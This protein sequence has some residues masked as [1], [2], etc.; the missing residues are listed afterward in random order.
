MQAQISAHAQQVSHHLQVPAYCM[1]A[2][3]TGLGSL[4]LLSAVHAGATMGTMGVTMSAAA[5]Q[6]KVVTVDDKT[7]INWQ[8]QTNIRICNE[9][10]DVIAL[11][12]RYPS[13]SCIGSKSIVDV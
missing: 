3:F 11:M 8:V 13:A 5:A 7:V 10:L 9:L 4:T 12:Q 6:P 1:L 2:S